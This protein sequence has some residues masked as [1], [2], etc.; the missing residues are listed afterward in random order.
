MYGVWTVTHGP[1]STAAPSLVLLPGALHLI[2]LHLSLCMQV[3]YDLRTWYVSFT[4][5][6][7]SKW[8]FFFY[9][10]LVLQFTS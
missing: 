4:Q 3:R 9:S 8:W 2:P 7:G 6:V 10:L 1:D 5:A